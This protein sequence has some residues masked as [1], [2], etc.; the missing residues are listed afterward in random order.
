MIFLL[1]CIILIDFSAVEI[2]LFFGRVVV[3]LTVKHK[4]CGKRSLVVNF[5]DTLC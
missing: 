2:S 4:D 3:F 5:S 1:W